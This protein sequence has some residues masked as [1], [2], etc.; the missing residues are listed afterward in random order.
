MQG[1]NI[2]RA[3]FFCVF[4][5]IGAV[6]LSGSVLCDVL[7]R[8]YQSKHLLHIQEQRAELLKELIADYNVLLTEVERDPN[9]VRRIAP[10]T[11]GTEADDTNI[12]NPKATDELQIAARKVLTEDPNQILVE[13]P[14]PV[15]LIRC[16]KPCRR[17]TLFLF[18]AGLII[19]SFICFRA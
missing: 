18:G 19:I 7:L 14:V 11:L 5:A 12:V 15:W 10:A 13:P 8:Y 9:F 1:Q 4:F 16:S 2:V 3:F 6:V 17:I